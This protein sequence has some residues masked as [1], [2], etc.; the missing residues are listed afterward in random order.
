[1]RERL[2][3]L[4][5]VDGLDVGG[6][7]TFSLRFASYLSKRHEV[8][9]YNLHA[10]RLESKLVDHLAPEVKILSFNPQ[11]S[12]VGILIWKLNGIFKKVGLAVSF[13]D[14]LKALHFRS[15]VQKY[16]IDIVNSHW[17]QADE[18]V[19]NALLNSAIPIII[20]MH[21]AYEM[22][23]RDKLNHPRFQEEAEII[24]KHARYIIYIAKKNLEIFKFSKYQGPIKRI[25]IGFT[26]PLNEKE[27]ISK[28][29]L[30]I[31]ERAFV[32]G[33]VAKGIPEK[34]W[35][36][37]IQAFYQ[38]HQEGFNHVHLVLVGSSKYLKT[39]EIENKEARNIHF[40]GFS[41]N[42][43]SF[44][45]LFDVGLLPTCFAGES[46]PNSI[47]EYLYEGKPIIATN[48]AEIEY[49]ISYEGKKAGTIIGLG[50]NGRA[51]A[52]ELKEAMKN[53]IIDPCLKSE[54]ATIAPLAFRKFSMEACV[55]AYEKVFDEVLR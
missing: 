21:G 27:G 10:E 38:L 18:L 35:E 12:L 22:Y 55:S 49:M 43:I 14:Q 1:L 51:D 19:T 37:A 42:P 17:F 53:Y 23:E 4:I 31:S 5:A 9:I 40:V 24:L 47:I 32:F 41:A 48:I 39:L 11:P 50:D 52:I 20:S 36:K 8:F 6:V 46:M 26:P 15:I 33:M 54:H 2:K 25:D 13:R 28:A 44:I 29:T 3:I 7:Q 45:S 30:N 34:G 16:K